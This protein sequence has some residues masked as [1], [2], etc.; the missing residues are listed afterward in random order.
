MD[1]FPQKAVISSGLAKACT[2][3]WDDTF[4]AINDDWTPQPEGCFTVPLSANNYEN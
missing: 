3:E 4:R 1:N 2:W